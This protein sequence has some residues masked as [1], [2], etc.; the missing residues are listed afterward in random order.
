MSEHA[1]TS[2]TL[3][4]RRYFTIQAVRLAGVVMVLLGI[5]V[6]NDKLAWPR[7]AGYFLVLDGLFNALFLPTLMAKRWKTPE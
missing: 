1:A 5:L 4:R 6:L 3:A 2:E 7:L